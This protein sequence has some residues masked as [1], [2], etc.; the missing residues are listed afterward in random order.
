MSDIA[1][2]YIK[3]DSKEVAVGRAELTKLGVTADG[4]G[5]KLD[6]MGRKTAVTADQMSSRFKVMGRDLSRY[7]TLPFL[8]ASGAS[9]KFASDLTTGLG[10]VETLIAGTGS[11]I[12]ELQELVTGLSSET[13]VSFDNLNRGLY[14]TISAFQDGADTAGRFEAAVKASVA[15]NASVLDSVKLISAVTKAYGDTSEEAAQKVTDLAFSAVKYGQTTFAELA[16]AIQGVTA[17]SNRLGVSQEE[18]FSTY[19]TLTGVTGTASEVT[20][21]FNRALLSLSNPT[22]AL[23]KLFAQ[24]RTEQGEVVTTGKEFLKVAGGTTQAFKIIYEAAKQ[25]GV[26]LEQY[27]T[28]ATGVIAVTALADQQFKTYAEKSSLVADSTGEMMKAYY[29]ATLGINEF[30]FALKQVKQTL[31]SAGAEIG[32]VLLPTIVTIAKQIAEAAQ[33]FSELDNSTQKT[34]IKFVAMAAAAGPLLILL[35]SMIK[36]VQGLGQALMILAANP[37]SFVI[38]AAAAT[39]AYLAM[40]PWLEATKNQIEQLEAMRKA[41]IGVN[42]ANSNFYQLTAAYEDLNEASDINKGLATDLVKI[43]GNDFKVALGG[44]EETVENLYNAMLKI[45][46]LKFQSE[47]IPQ[48]KQLNLLMEQQ[49]GLAKEIISD[50]MYLKS[51]PEMAET[52]KNDFGDMASVIK[53]FNSDAKGLK[54]T[55]GNLFYRMAQDF[56]NSQI[57]YTEARGN[58]TEY[59][60]GIQSDIEARSNGL[61]TIQRT[62]YDEATELTS[63]IIVIPNAEYK[64]AGETAGSNFADGFGDAAGD[65]DTATRIKTWEDYFSEIAGVAGEAFARVEIIKGKA[66]GFIGGQGKLAANAFVNSFE[67]ELQNEQAIANALGEVFD[68]TDKLKLLEGQ[69]EKSK[70]ILSDLLNIPAREIRGGVDGVFRLK[71]ALGELSEGEL[72]DIYTR[73]NLTD[74]SIQG[75]I[76]AT[77]EWNSELE[78][79]KYALDLTEFMKAMEELQANKSPFDFSL[80]G[81]SNDKLALIKTR[82]TDIK[83]EMEGTTDAGVRMMQQIELD[84][85]SGQ[86]ADLEL[87]ISAVLALLS[88]APSLGQ[89]FGHAMFEAFKSTEDGAEVFNTTLTATLSVLGGVIDAMLSG[90]TD[91]A[92][93][94]GTLV[95]QMMAGKDVAEAW[96]NVMGDFALNIAKTLSQLAIQ[97]GMQLIGA[98]ASV[99]ALSGGLNPAGW[100]LIG[101]GTLMMGTG[102]AG[103]FITSAVEGYANEKQA[104][105]NA[106]GGVYSNGVKMYAKGAVLSDFA[107]S[108]VNKPTLFNNGTAMMGEAGAEAIIPLTRSSNGEL[109]VNASGINAQGGKVNVTVYNYG[110]DQAEVSETTNSEGDT[111]IMITIGKAVNGLIS[112]GK[113][114]SSMKGRYGIQPRGLN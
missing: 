113:M 23:S 22:K 103:T 13:G 81:F 88:A 24:Y 3:V 67:Q 46:A 85:L 53:A 6:A 47:M 8:A 41:A 114:D 102:L 17:N 63:S 37:L 69:V 50:S 104:Q 7:I 1:T 109:G 107:N 106:N 78:K 96:D 52:V 79:T 45:E 105:A 31:A 75:V 74:R 29:S 110:S 62:F 11:R 51:Y 32:S 97:V 20:T 64:K 111:D 43:Y 54:D 98:G 44:A 33:R 5:Q 30:Q 95:G 38:M 76:D 10:Q 91:I 108:I 55:Y 25:S 71:D 59:L 15:G 19:A 28:R 39:A 35:G 56:S 87:N 60:D 84:T 86:A 40:A 9:L 112:T 2:L 70:R 36:L 83:Q 99:L 94:F 27:I 90:L 18:L 34:I 12:Y 26:P 93:G 61:L 82:I 66:V 68:G 89:A 65:G 42:N 58:L 73:F 77:R 80:D 72:E 16:N 92:S 57:D 14:E 101:M 4:T 49:R 100:G 21:Q 48:T